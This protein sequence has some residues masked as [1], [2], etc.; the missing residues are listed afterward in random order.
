[1]VG[2]KVA[3]IENTGAKAVVSG[4]CG[5]LMNINGALEGGKKPVR[6]VHIAQFLKE[7]THG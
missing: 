7:R 2:D 3:D 1:M 6:G 4:D 5:C